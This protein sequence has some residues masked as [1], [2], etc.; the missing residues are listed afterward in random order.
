M[1]MPIMI[2]RLGRRCCGRLHRTVAATISTVISATV[3]P[4][5][6]LR[7]VLRLRRGVVPAASVGIIGLGPS[8]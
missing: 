5:A 1:T 3:L 6:L 4:A 2:C 7:M 8:G